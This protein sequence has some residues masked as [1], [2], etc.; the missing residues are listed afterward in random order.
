MGGWMRVSGR[1][2]FVFVAGGVLVVGLTAAVVVVARDAGGSPHSAA[3]VDDPCL[4]GAWT[5]ISH[6]QS[7]MVDGHMV[8]FVGHGGIQRFR[9]DGISVLDLAGGQTL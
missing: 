8:H 1:L 6:T 9:A 5:E 7:G 3:S 2:V 4:V